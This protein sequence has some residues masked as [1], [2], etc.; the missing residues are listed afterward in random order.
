MVFHIMHWTVFEEIFSPI[1]WDNIHANNSTVIAV[2]FNDNFS[3]FILV[4]SWGLSALSKYEY[5]YSA[6]S[7]LSSACVNIFSSIRYEIKLHVC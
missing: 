2:C 3:T 4:N 5:G 6:S 7:L 1:I